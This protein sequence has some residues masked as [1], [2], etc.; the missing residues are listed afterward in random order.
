MRSL[1][2]YFRR[3]F[4][5]RFLFIACLFLLSPA[6]AYADTGFSIVCLVYYACKDAFSPL[7][8]IISS[9]SYIAGIYLTSNGI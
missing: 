9:A 7:F 5:F 6:L 8:I 3:S 4:M 1:D 2:K